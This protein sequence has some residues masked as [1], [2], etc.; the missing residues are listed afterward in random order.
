MQLKCKA[1][2]TSFSTITMVET[3]LFFALFFHPS[4]WPVPTF[5]C[6]FSFILSTL[7]TSWSKICPDSCLWSGM[8]A[9][10]VIHLLA[11]MWVSGLLA[12]SHP[13]PF[14]TNSFRRSVLNL[15]C[16]SLL[17][18]YVSPKLRRVVQAHLSGGPISVQVGVGSAVPIFSLSACQAMHSHSWSNVSWSRF[19]PSLSSL[20]R[21]QRSA[22]KSI[23]FGLPEIGKM[24]RHANICS[25]YSDSYTEIIHWPA[26]FSSSFFLTAVE[27]LFL[28]QLHTCEWIADSMQLH[29]S[30]LSPS[31]WFHMLSGSTPCCI[32]PFWFISDWL[33]IY[34]NPLLSVAP[35]EH[36]VNRWIPTFQIWCPCIHTPL[37]STLFIVFCI[38]CTHL[39]QKY[40]FTLHLTVQNQSEIVSKFAWT[41]AYS[42]YCTS[43]WITSLRLALALLTLT[44]A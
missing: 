43:P 31:T 6:I 35:H 40:K 22:C 13:K 4:H 24:I 39:L 5:P 7:S 27:S 34:F 10:S 29:F 41:F 32:T 25:E 18:P 9:P 20:S 30:P 15:A 26:S 28:N 2:L 11:K 33:Y 37:V 19:E 23:C 42:Q 36:S 3:M 12:K 8:T 17:R 16:S 14:A 21:R 44:F 1:S 38:Y